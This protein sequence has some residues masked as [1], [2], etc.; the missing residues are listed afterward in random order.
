MYLKKEAFLRVFI[1][2]EI[3]Q[4]NIRPPKR[5]VRVTFA[6]M[7]FWKLVFYNVIRNFLTKISHKPFIFTHEVIYDKKKL[8]CNVGYF[9]HE[10]KLIVFVHN[11]SCPPRV[12][13]T[14]LHKISTSWRVSNFVF[15]AAL[16]S[17]SVRYVRMQLCQASPTSPE[18][19]VVQIS[20]TLEVHLT[21]CIG[22][23]W[24]PLVA[25]IDTSRTCFV[26]AFWTL[27]MY[28]SFRMEVSFLAT[29]HPNFFKIS[30]KP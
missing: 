17:V 3:K 12:Q 23:G 1:F 20:S 25:F 8:P 11:S 7:I 5:N 2:Y 24:L 14:F 28:G 13:C 19:P 29:Y 10:I 21:C 22:Q 30:W 27:V 15:T 26:S 9:C 16:I 6:A 18:W 4:A